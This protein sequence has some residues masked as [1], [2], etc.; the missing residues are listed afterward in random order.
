MSG[1][2]GAALGYVRPIVPEDV[3]RVALLYAKVFGH[4]VQA[5]E[6]LQATLHEV[7]FCH[8]WPDDRLPSLVY[9]AKDGRILGCL[10][11]VMVDPDSRTTL[12]GVELIRAF[13]SGPQDVSISQGTTES[14][15]IFEAVGG[16]TSLLH[17][18]GW[19]RVLR[20]SR[21]VLGS[22]RGRGLPAGIAAALTPVC[23]AA[24]ALAGR[25]RP[26]R[27]SAAGLS[28]EPLEPE[29]L[30]IC[31]SELSRDRALRPT[32]DAGS[33]KWLLDLLARQT[34]EFALHGTIVRDA[35]AEIVGGYLYR[36]SST[37]VG[38]VVQIVADPKWAEAVLDHLFSDAHRRGLTAVSGQLDPRFLPA[39]GAK[40]CLF[41]RG[42]G[43]WLMAYSRDPE[44]LGA[45]H[46]GDALLTR[47][48]A[49]WWIGFVLIRSLALGGSDAVHGC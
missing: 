4:R 48:E 37:G 12:A 49:E 30:G 31:V 1:R 44:V 45:I 36:Q 40:H 35:R 13:L 41:T 6:G 2:D 21:Y 23:R 47:L 11:V 32:Y 3:P 5:L 29:T 14:R 42:D 18:M 34:G 38:D 20:P 19:I 33:L 24:D 43:S 46:R 10:G 17:S 16:T 26:F 8:P 15:R 25:I 39:L 9:E 7:F 27:L 22:L 28:G